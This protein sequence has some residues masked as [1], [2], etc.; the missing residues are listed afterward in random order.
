MTKVEELKEQFIETR[1]QD[2]SAVGDLEELLQA[3]RE[4]EKGIFDSMFKDLW[5]IIGIDFLPKEDK[6]VLIFRENHTPSVIGAFYE[7]NHEY[8]EFHN[9]E[10]D[11]ERRIV[12]TGI[13][14][15]SNV[16]PE[17]KLETLTQPTKE[18]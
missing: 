14:A 11:I 5:H 13:T 4:E 12:Y 2:S 6:P 16:L 8:G 10:E 17:P 15:W 1:C 18:K 7:G 9:G 3:V